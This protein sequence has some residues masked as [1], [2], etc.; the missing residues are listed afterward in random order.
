MRF[1][2]NSADSLDAE[3]SR[4]RWCLPRSSLRRSDGCWR[5]SR[6][7]GRKRRL[8]SPPD[9]A[10]LG[11]SCRSTFGLKAGAVFSVEKV[12]IARAAFVACCDV[13]EHLS[14][15]SPRASRNARSV[16]NVLVIKP[17]HT[18]LARQQRLNDFPLKLTQLMS[19][20]RKGSFSES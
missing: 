2:G 10:A 11:V 1:A 15:K 4:Q 13:A 7:I 5:G 9:C 12:S 17:W 16:Q 20:Y 6:T 18:P 19:A 14:G 3:K 8:N